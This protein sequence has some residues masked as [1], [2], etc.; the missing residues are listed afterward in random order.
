[1]A[2]LPAEYDIEDVFKSLRDGLS[3]RE[4][5]R[6]ALQRRDKSMLMY[7]KDLFEAKGITMPDQATYADIKK[8]AEAL[9]DKGR[10]YGITLRG[11]P[12]WER[13]WPMSAR[14]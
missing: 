4:A 13:T 2:N 12:G 3:G 9:T 11:K 10:I 14:W 1:M 5:L 8:W 6:A 7:R